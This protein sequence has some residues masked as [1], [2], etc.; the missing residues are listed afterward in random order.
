MPVD[1]T[2]P[3][4][5]RAVTVDGGRRHVADA[6]GD[7]I[8]YTIT[9]EN[10]GNVTLDGVTV[11]DP[12][13]RS[14]PTPRATPVG[15]DATLE[16][17]ET[18]TYTAS[19]TVTQA[20]IDAGGGNI[21]QRPATANDVRTMTAPDTDDASVPVTQA[22]T[23]TSSR[24]AAST[25]ADGTVVDAAG[26]VI[27]YTITVEN[28][29]NMTLTGVT[30]SDSRSST[31]ARP[32]SRATPA[33]RRRSRSAR[34]GPTRPLHGHPGR[35]RRGR[36][37]R[38]RRPGRPCPTTYPTAAPPTD[39][40][41]P[42]TDADSVPRRPGPDPEHRQ[43]R[44]RSTAATRRRGRRPDQLHDHRREHRQ[45]DAHRLIVTDPLGADPPRR[46]TPP[47]RDGDLLEV[48][49]TW[50]SRAPTRSPRPTSTPAAAR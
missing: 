20:D 2:R 13:D 10:T 16:V 48:G 15:D 37:L 45:R 28:T 39:Q 42:D 6:A 29:G 24:A 23:S 50:T 25:A 47:Q 49:E 18:W 3:R 31:R 12:C 19:Y 32:T 46:S 17:G 7:V 27:S 22:A 14:R 8:S 44:P 38:H 21:D 40:T 35:H 4:I 43:E 11:T 30:V 1:Q 5:A 41:G 9:V 33:R 34:P 26:D 36:Q